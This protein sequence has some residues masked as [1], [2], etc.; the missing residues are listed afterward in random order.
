MAASV[1]IQLYTVRD[2]CQTDFKGTLRALAEMG[3]QG[4]EFAGRYGDLKPRELAG[5]LNSVGLQAAGVH[6]SLDHILNP[7]SDGY[8]YARA[9]NS[10]FVTTSLCGEVAK[11]WMATIDRMAQAASVAFSQGFTF[12][13]H[14]HAQE[15]GEVNGVLAQDR[16]LARPSLIQFELDTY[17]IKKGGQDP[18]ATIRRYSGR[19]PQVHL[20]DMDKEDG[21]FAEAGHGSL[22]LPEILK[23]VAANGARW[24]IVEQDKCKRPPLE[25]ARMSIDAL[26]QAGVVA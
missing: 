2:L 5:F 4:V 24:L 13:Y 19:S 12:T 26:K 1:G 21:S 7:G 9:I 15:F 14:N 10:S 8:A 25:S 16:V 17:W 18:A 11:D 20:K 6:I 3:Y 23:A 22:D